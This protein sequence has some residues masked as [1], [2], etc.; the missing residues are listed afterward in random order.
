MRR[1]VA[2]ACGTVLLA[3]CA[4][5]APRDADAGFD[6]RLSPASLGREL[7]LQQ[8]LRYREGAQQRTFDAL[9]EA[10]ATEVR[11]DIQALGQSALRIRWDG[12]HLEQQR[13]PWLPKSVRA[14]RILGD[15]QLAN[16]PATAI[17]AGLPPGWSLVET[18]SDTRQLRHGAT[19]IATVRYVASDRI[20][21]D[22][23]NV[24]LS[25][26]SAPAQ[27]ANP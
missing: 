23:A 16:W 19:T 8:Q 5:H 4:G 18:G 22:R 7:A 17:R 24:H 10:D 1:R 2:L 20:E 11:L 12:A 13:A 27:P 3:A 21:I 25:I 15:M 26:V 6:L 14:E 9:L